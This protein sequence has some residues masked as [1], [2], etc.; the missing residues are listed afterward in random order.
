MKNF[1]RASGGNVFRRGH[2]GTNFL[3][4]IILFIFVCAGSLLLLG[5]SLVVVHGLLITVA[6]LIAEHGL[7]G[8]WASV[9][10][11]CGLSSCN[12]SPGS[13]AQ[14]QACGLA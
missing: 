13:R 4:K 5:L 2:N 11:A 9:V 12:S 8:A 14:A 3:K 7:Q 10:G 6:F 1:G